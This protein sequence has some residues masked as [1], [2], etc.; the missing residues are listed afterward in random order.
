MNCQKK[1]NKIFQC[2]KSAQIC[3]NQQ[4]QAE[5]AKEKRENS[6]KTTENN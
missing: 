4:N 1:A 3:E 6:P 2:V 5:K